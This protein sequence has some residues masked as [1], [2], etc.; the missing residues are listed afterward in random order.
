MLLTLYYTCIV[1]SLLYKR[2]FS[3]RNYFKI[4]NINQ[5]FNYLLFCQKRTKKMNWECER[6]NEMK[7]R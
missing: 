3:F 2:I 6:E 5:F 7:I 1:E 4:K